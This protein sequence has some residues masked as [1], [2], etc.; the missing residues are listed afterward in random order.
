MKSVY[1]NYAVEGRGAD[2]APNGQFFVTRSDM[3]SLVDEVL[4]NNMGFNDPVKKQDYSDAHFPHTW[5]HFDLFNK[6]YLP[7]NE[8]PQFLRLIVGEVEV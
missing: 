7:V 4:T 5:N 2:G 8:V 3:Q 6:G 1:T